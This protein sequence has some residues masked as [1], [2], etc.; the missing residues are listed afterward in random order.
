MRP[1]FCLKLAISVPVLAA[2]LILDTVAALQ[3]LPTLL[4]ALGIALL[5]VER[6][7]VWLKAHG[8]AALATLPFMAAALVLLLAFCRGRNLSQGVLLLVTIAVV[9]DILLIALAVIGETTKRRLRGLAEFA[10]LTGLGLA[11]GLAL[12]LLFLLEAGWRA[13]ASLAGP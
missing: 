2:L 1:S 3:G 11:L 13:G 9:F 12:S 4:A 8:R 6:L 10:G 7:R 5:V